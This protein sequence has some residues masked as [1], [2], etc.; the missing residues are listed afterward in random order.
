MGWAPSV[1]W[2]LALLSSL[3]TSVGFLLVVRIGLLAAVT[4]AFTGLVL[5]GT[6]ATLDFGSWYAGLALLPMGLLLGIAAYGAAT[7]LAGKSILGDPLEDG[8]R[9]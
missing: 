5:A 6:A 7:T 2:K 9:R 8:P 4:S 1:G 3:W